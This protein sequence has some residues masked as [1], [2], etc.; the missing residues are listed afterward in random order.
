LRVVAVATVHWQH[1]FFMNWFGNQKGEGFEYHLLAIGI[2]VA[3]VI[4]GGGRWALDS[5][6]HRYLSDLLA[7]RNARKGLAVART[8]KRQTEIVGNNF[9]QA[10]SDKDYQTSVPTLF[11][12]WRLPWSLARLAYRAEERS[13]KAKSD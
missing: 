8:S 4:T 13:T 2:A 7:L 12:F 5:Q 1:G 3:L 10:M 6:L 11:G 9:A